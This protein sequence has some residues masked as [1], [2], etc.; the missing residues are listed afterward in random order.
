MAERRWA[1]APLQGLLLATLV[2]L[3]AV[4]MVMEMG[5][6][7]GNKNGKVPPVPGDDSII[8]QA[9]THPQLLTMKEICDNKVPLVKMS[10]DDPLFYPSSKKN[11]QVESENNNQ[12]ESNMFKE[13]IINNQ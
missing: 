7:M 11:Y 1:L 2:M 6:G 12:V 9:T 13:K 8:S 5:M 4:A 3:V 10:Q